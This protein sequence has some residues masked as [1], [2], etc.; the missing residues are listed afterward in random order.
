MA[1]STAE[2]LHRDGA[3]YGK[4]GA[5]TSERASERGTRELRTHL[6]R[7]HDTEEVAIFE[8]PRTPGS[9]DRPGCPASQQEESGHR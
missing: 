7:V 2:P 4:T 5:H 1:A 8:V 9:C 3:R 6:K